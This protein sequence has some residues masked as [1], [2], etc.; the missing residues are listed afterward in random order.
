VLQGLT[1]LKIFGGSRRQ[2]ESI[3]SISERFRRATMRM[4]RVAFFSSL[5]LELGA[6]ISTAVIAVEVG[7]RLLNGVMPFQTALFVL[8]LAPEY[9][10]PL[11]LLGARYHAGMT[12]KVAQQ[13]IAEILGTPSSVTQL[14]SVGTARVTH[15]PTL[16]G[17]ST[18]SQGSEPPYA[19]SSG[20]SSLEVNSTQHEGRPGSIRFECVS[21]SYDGMRPALHEVSFD[22][23][24]RQ[25]VALVGP[26]GAGKSTVVQLLL[27][28]IEAEHGRIVVGGT[29]IEQIAVQQ[30][31]KHIAWV[32]EHPYLFHATVADNIRLGD[33]HASLPA[34]IKAAQD[35]CAHECIEA[36]PQGYDT[37]IGEQGHFLSGGEAQRISLARAF[38]KDAPLLILDEATSFLDTANQAGIVEAIDRLKRD[39]TALIIAHRLSTVYDADLIVVIENGMIVAWGTHN[40]LMTQSGIYNQLVGA[41]RGG[42]S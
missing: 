25:K 27:R 28:F 12:G 18:P 42:T 34:V 29:P 30:W 24:S 14:S 16:E 5:A 7:L 13:R 10:L 11:R 1:T 40:E 39:R 36:L 35:A 4:L 22:I 2:V 9:F 6:T 15:H 26:S 31:R 3:R 8:L 33:K 19:L 17:E 37:V 41:Y 21:Y 20:E 23:H 38:L 32:P